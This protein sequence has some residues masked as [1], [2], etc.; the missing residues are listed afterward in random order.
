VAWEWKEVR[1]GKILTFPEGQVF[2]G[3]F[4]LTPQFIFVTS[5]KEG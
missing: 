1:A 5:L 2:A 3:V 4:D